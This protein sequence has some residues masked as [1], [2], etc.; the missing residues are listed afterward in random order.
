MQILFTRLKWKE[1]VKKEKAHG[2]NLIG[3][4]RGR[5]GLG[6]DLRGFINVFELS[7]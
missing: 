2:F 4:S 6:E 7:R 1:A 3:Y 5:L